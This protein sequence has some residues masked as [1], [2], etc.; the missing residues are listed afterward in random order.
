MA[1]GR[2]GPV[3]ANRLA[4]ETEMPTVIVPMSPDT[5]SAL[6]LLVTD[7]KHDYSTTYIKR[8]D[9]KHI[10]QLDVAAVERTYQ[11]LEEEGQATLTREGIAPLPFLS[12]R[13]H[14]LERRVLLQA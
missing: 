12:G 6:G 3:H 5:T 4:A 11:T 13:G 14:R 8:V 9:I 1:F 10:D 7:L 2:A